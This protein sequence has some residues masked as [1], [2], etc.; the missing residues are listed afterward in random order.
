M[1]GDNL[2]C[3]AEAIVALPADIVIAENPKIYEGADV[4]G[5]ALLWT[6]YA[7]IW[8]L[9]SLIW[10]VNALMS[11]DQSCKCTNEDRKIMPWPNVTHKRTNVDPPKVSSL[12]WSFATKFACCGHEGRLIWTKKPSISIDREEML[13]NLSRGAL[14]L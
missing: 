12:I 10:I 14:S 11:T 7:L 9:S 2:L 8:T 1:D 13:A 5:P 4:G 6:V 3:V